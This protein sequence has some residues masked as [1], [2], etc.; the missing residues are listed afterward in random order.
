VLVPDAGL[1]EVADR[2]WV[3]RHRYLDVNATV[4][5]G[6]RGV[7][8]VDTLWSEQAAR[9]LLEAVRALACGEVVAVVNTH[10]HFDHVLGNR[11]VAAGLPVFAHEAAVAEISAHVADVQAQVTDDPDEPFGPDIAGSHVG[12]PDHAFSS[13]AAVDLGSR[14][15]ELVHAGRGHTAGDVVVR[16][17]D[18]EV[19]LVGDLVEESGPPGFGPDCFPLEW[20]GALDLALQL[21]TGSSLVVPGHGDVVDRAFVEEQRAD[22]G[23]VAENIH[24]LAG[25]GVPVEEA[26]DGADWPFPKD[27]LRDAV[28]RGYDQLPRAARRLPL[29]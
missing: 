24:D 5:A 20:P 22:I 6:D 4:V 19:L 18:A 13:A 29:V 26:L 7:L 10:H 16:V 12:V 14:F 15:V 8:V 3:A 2:V 27:R 21:T 17:P 1:T 25:R 23:V 11:A 28:L 9:T